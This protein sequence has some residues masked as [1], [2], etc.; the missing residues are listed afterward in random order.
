M[1]C[2]NLKKKL[3]LQIEKVIKSNVI[4]PKILPTQEV[5]VYTTGFVMKYTK[6]QSLS[7]RMVT[8]FV[9]HWNL[10]GIP[11]VFSFLLLFLRLPNSRQVI[12]SYSQ[13]PPSN[14]HFKFRKCSS[15]RS[16]ENVSQFKYLRTTVTNQNLV[17]E[18]IKRRLNSGNACY[19]SV[20]NP[21]SSRLLSKK[22]KNY[23]I[24]DYNFACCSV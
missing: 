9:F 2:H 10:L 8:G 15:N 24:K 6:R 12:C 23:N 14:T 16:F 4:P 3:F 17:E 5:F 22:L 18:E 20:Q 1:N 13:I 7:K 19:H 11:N 21:L